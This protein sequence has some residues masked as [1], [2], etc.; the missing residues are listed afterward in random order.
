MKEKKV[1]DAGI[2][3][4]RLTTVKVVQV[5]D[6]TTGEKRDKILLAFHVADK[7]AE[8]A[9]FF[10]P[11]CADASHIV[12]FLKA[13]CGDEFT[14]AIQN[15]ADKMWSFVQQLQGQDFQIVVVKNGQWNNIT[16]AIKAK[17]KDPEP[18]LTE[19][20]LFAFTDETVNL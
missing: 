15:D 16:T 10:T 11:S 18:Q 9:A 19:E 1:I 2:Y 4:A 20:D 3:N 8:V 7:D 13:S 17:K 6:K 14:P 12:K 5:K